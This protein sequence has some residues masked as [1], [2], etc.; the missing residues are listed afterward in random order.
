MLAVLHFLSPAQQKELKC[1]YMNGYHIKKHHQ[2]VF[3]ICHIYVATKTFKSASCFEKQSSY[4]NYFVVTQFF[5]LLKNTAAAS[6]MLY[7]I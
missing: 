4:F 2:N 7:I 3:R 5:C 1:Y 6:A